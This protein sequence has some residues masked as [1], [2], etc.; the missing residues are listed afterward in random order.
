M[1]MISGWTEAIILSLTFVA[2]LTLVVAG[3][4]SMYGQNYSLGLSDNSSTETLFI[5]Y[6]NTSQ[7]QLVGG[8]VAFDAQQGITLKSSYDMAKDVVKII[9]GF[10]TGNWIKDVFT[11]LKLGGPG[12]LLARAF[13]VIWFLSLIFAMLYALFK[14]VV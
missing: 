7:E 6:Q 14:V 3:F 11:M 12:L 9:W 8:E 4:N 2:V 10:L 13:Q 1:G 5:T